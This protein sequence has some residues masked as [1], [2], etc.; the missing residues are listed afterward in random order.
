MGG[1]QDRDIR[2][3]SRGPLL[4]GVETD[5]PRGRVRRPGY[6]A[7]RADAPANGPRGE[8]DRIGV[9][10]PGVE[11]GRTTQGRLLAGRLE[12]FSRSALAGKAEPRPGLDTIRQDV[13]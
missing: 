2:D 6:A 12:G 11:E 3:R 13:R 4:A 7:G 1:L 9:G 10:D 8:A 5:P